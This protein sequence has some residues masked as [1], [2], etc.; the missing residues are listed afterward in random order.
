MESSKFE[1][2]FFFFSSFCELKRL[3][4]LARYSFNHYFCNYL[5]WDTIIEPSNIIRHYDKTR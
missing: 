3:V 1:P 2:H 5:Y 4:F